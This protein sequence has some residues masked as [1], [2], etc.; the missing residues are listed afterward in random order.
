MHVVTTSYWPYQQL[1]I[2][3]LFILFVQCS[4][5]IYFLFCEREV[6][7]LSYRRLESSKICT[8]TFNINVLH[9]FVDLNNFNNQIDYQKRCK[10][11]MRTLAHI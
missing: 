10:T 8:P 9:Y 11:Q 3:I 4:V 6:N 1:Y 7:Y 5:I 2:I